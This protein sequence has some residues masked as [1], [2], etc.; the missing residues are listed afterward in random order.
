[1]DFEIAVVCLLVI[2]YII[3]IIT[4]FLLVYMCLKVKS[5]TS[6]HRS[7]NTHDTYPDNREETTQTIQTTSNI[8]G[9]LDRSIKSETSIKSDSIGK[10]DESHIYQEIEDLYIDD[11]IPSNLH[12]TLFIICQHLNLNQNTNWL[13]NIC[14]PEN[15]LTFFNGTDAS[16]TSTHLCMSIPVIQDPRQNRKVLGNCH[17]YT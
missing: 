7:I 10:S 5:N 8:K 3:A 16:Y 6:S 2:L 9:L 12:N 13:R 1:M 11:S 14:T 17:F 4:V 15:I